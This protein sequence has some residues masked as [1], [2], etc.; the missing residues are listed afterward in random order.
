MNV[1]PT[2]IMSSK[3]PLVFL[4]KLDM[5]TSV[6]TLPSSDD[7]Y[8]N[9]GTAFGRDGLTQLNPI[10]QVSYNGNDYFVCVRLTAYKSSVPYPFDTDKVIDARN[11]HIVRNESGE[12]ISYKIDEDDNKNSTDVL[13]F[14]IYSSL[15]FESTNSGDNTIIYGR[16]KAIKSKF[17]DSTPFMFKTTID[18]QE[19]VLVA[20]IVGYANRKK[21]MNDYSIANESKMLI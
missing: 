3:F 12:P 7:N 19:G 17:L 2:S 5:G 18:G 1:T 16:L 20:S 4:S 21:L 10:V 14:P 13:F 6:V 15:G 9:S 11:I 8:M